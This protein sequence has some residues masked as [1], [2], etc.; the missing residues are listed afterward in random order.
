MLLH[1]WFVSKLYKSTSRN[2]NSSN[3]EALRLKIFVIAT[4]W[5]IFSCTHEFSIKHAKT[6]RKYNIYKSIWFPCWNC[7][8]KCNCGLGYRL[9][10]F[11]INEDF[12]QL[13]QLQLWISNNWQ[14]QK[15]T[16]TRS[17]YCILTFAS[18]AS[19]SFQFARKSEAVISIERH[20]ISTI[21][22]F[23][24]F[25]EPFVRWSIARS[26]FITPITTNVDI[27]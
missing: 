9:F 27:S 14:L 17:N 7:L 19:Y 11:I 12:P 8:L 10:P 2:D 20:F 1:K 3:L 18:N 5:T 13:S 25:D 16:C 21:F 15:S 23:S 26:W 6:L 4:N 22:C 24:A